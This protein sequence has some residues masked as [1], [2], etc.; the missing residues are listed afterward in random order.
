[1]QKS[2]INKKSEFI[3]KIFY[4]KKLS[5]DLC[6]KGLDFIRRRFFEEWGVVRT[7]VEHERILTRRNIV[8]F[9]EE[10]IIGWLGVEINNEFTTAC[11][12]NSRNGVLILRDMIEFYVKTEPL[13]EYFAFVPIEKTGSARAFLMSGWRVNKPDCIIK[14]KYMKKTITLIKMVFNE[15]QKNSIDI[16]QEIAYIR[17]IN[18]QLNTM[19]DI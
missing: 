14:N 11:I 1:M 16:E 17:R 9:K 4:P 7:D 3:I 18:N 6:H 5:I 19:E 15:N 13:N 2:L 10:V 12:D 8:I